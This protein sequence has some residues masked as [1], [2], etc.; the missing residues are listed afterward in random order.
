MRFKLSLLLIM[1]FAWHVTYCQQDKN[2]LNDTLELKN[3]A[4]K[5]YTTNDGLPSNST[6]SAITDEKGFLWVG[7]QNGLCRFDGY[8][9]KTFV[10]IPGDT[11][12]LTN[13]YVN[14]LIMDKSGRIWVGTLD[15]LNLLDPVTEKFTR[16][17]HHDE[18]PRSLSNNKVWSL[19]ADRD[20]NIWV[21]T[22]DG[23]DKFVE[24]SR[25][26]DV[27]QPNALNPYAMKGKSVNS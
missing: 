7:T 14:A 13:N 6:T 9:F 27:Y 26:F 18:N 22:D 24:N 3:Y 10:N 8:S 12:S 2:P 15:G 25:D 5:V 20:N 4:I 19:L 16:F 23:F 1:L 17:S 11:T 21:G